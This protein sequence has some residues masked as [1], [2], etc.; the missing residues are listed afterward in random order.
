MLQINTVTCIQRSMTSGEVLQICRGPPK[1]SKPVPPPGGG[2]GGGSAP[3]APRSPCKWFAKGSCRDGASCLF[4]HAA[5][6]GGG[7]APG[8]GGG[9]GES[10]AVCRWHAKGGCRDGA[11]CRYLHPESGGPIGAGWPRS[12]TG[13]G[14]NKVTTPCQWET[15]GGCKSRATCPYLH[16]RPPPMKRT[17][18]PEDCA[19]TIGKFTVKALRNKRLTKRQ[20]RC[21][22]A[23]PENYQCSPVF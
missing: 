5:T 9:G 1:S 10:T 15:R 7:A 12:P 14:G 3:T 2:P 13:G 20:V 6:G 23:T 22:T 19:S 21:H 18:T 11:R 16:K 17:K 8:H 4:A